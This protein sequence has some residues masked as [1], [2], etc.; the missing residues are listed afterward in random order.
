MSNKIAKNNKAVNEK[1]MSV[2]K[3][4][5][6]KK[7]NPTPDK[8]VT[9]KYY[10]SSDD[11]EPPQKSSKHITNGGLSKMD[12]SSNCNSIQSISQHEDRPYDTIPFRLDFLKDILQNN[13]LEPIVEIDDITTEGFIHPNG[14]HVDDDDDLSHDIRSIMNKQTHDFYSVITQI[15]GK[16]SYIKSGST[17]HTFKGT[18]QMDDGSPNID[19]AVKVVAYPKNKQ[20]GTMYDIR[21]PENAELLMIRLL[22]YFIIKGC[23][24]HITLPIGTFYTS[25]DPFTNLIENN[26]VK[27]DNKKYIE[28]IQKYKNG[29]YHDNVSILI[30]E[31]ANRGDLLDFIRKNH[32]EF[33]T[34]HW[35][36]IFFQVISVLAVIQ[37][38]FPAFRHND[39][40]ANNVLIHKVQQKGSMCSYKV[41]HKQYY[42]KNIGYRC[43]IWDF[44]FACIP[45]V[46]EN[47]KV[48]TEWTNEINVK[49]EQN[50]Y[51]DLHY[52]FCTLIRPGFF[53]NLMTDSHIDQ[54]IKDFINRIVPKK[55]QYGKKIKD[56]V[57]KNGKKI[58]DAKYEIISERGRLLVNDEYVTPNDVLMKDPF[59]E[60]FRNYKPKK[61]N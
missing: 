46:V 25:I 50:R 24:P 41:Q 38:K 32:R 20:Y 47:F 54:S 39:L 40:K 43:K 58:A 16:L 42:V 18:I 51:Y 15:G 14:Y 55:Y 1:K 22:S 17:G 3:T 29:G 5:N 57:F 23:T 19:Y 35:K 52:F 61:K 27:S 34:L 11:S 8:Q 13:K 37:S 36:V 10:T 49:P 4:T 60:E 12:N 21:R 7:L 56:A 48:N 44:D 26:F 9:K 33:T 28:F 31:W 45:G 30:S 2:I 59:F 53:P 6:V